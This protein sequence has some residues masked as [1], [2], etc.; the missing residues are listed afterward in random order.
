MPAADEAPDQ[1]NPGAAL[2]DDVDAPWA[3]S[4]QVTV[5]LAQDEYMQLLDRVD[6]IEG[7]PPASARRARCSRGRAPKSTSPPTTRTRRLHPSAPHR[8][9]GSSSP[10]S[11]SQTRSHPA[12][13]PQPTQRSSISRRSISPERLS[14]APPPCSCRRTLLTPIRPSRSSRWAQPA[15]CRHDPL[16]LP[17]AA[18]R[19]TLRRSDLPGAAGDISQTLA[20]NMQLSV[21]LVSAGSRLPSCS[22]ASGHR[23]ASRPGLP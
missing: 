7:A 21:C 18:R 19:S 4:S 11:S 2:G 3:P 17:R 9:P 22:A 23:G 14:R 10:I 6:R 16:V 13:T 8:R 15:Q 5:T 20:P 12:R 1:Q